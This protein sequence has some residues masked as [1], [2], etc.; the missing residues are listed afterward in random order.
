[1]KVSLDWIKDYV[2]LGED[3]DS[4]R[5]AYDLTMS[6]VEVEDVIDL[7]ASFENM[8]LGVLERVEAHPNADKLRVCAVNLGDRTE[9]IVCG[10]SNLREGMKVAAALPGAKVR[11]HGEGELTEIKRAKLRGVESF[12]M[13]CAASEIG[14]ADLFPA[15]SET[16]I[17]D[18]TE[19]DAPAGTPLADA[20][21]L[22]DVI[23]EIDNKSMT[24]R[25]DLWGHYGI[26]REIAALYDLPL[27]ELVPF[28]PLGLPPLK[29]EVLDSGRCP[30]YIG[31]LIEG[32]SV[33]A[34]P[35]IIRRRVWETG[36]RP[37][38][39]LVD[40]TNYV[41][42]A[43]GNP[44]HA[45]DADHIKGNIVVRRARQ[46]E[47]L[48]L[49]NGRE[50]SL[51][52][53][54]LVIADTESAVGLA[55]VMGGA[56]DSVLADTNRIILE[57]AN[58][59]GAGIRGTALRYDNRTDASTRYEKEIDPQ[60]CDVALALSMDLLRGLY[61]QMRITAFTDEY[62]APAEPTVIDV[63]LAWLAKRLGGG[64]DREVTAN[65][66]TRLGFTVE[67]REDTLHITVPSWRDTG[68]ISL[69]DDIME[70]IARM[71][72]YENFE[73][74]PITTAF[75]G[76]INQRD[77]DL[78][79]AVKEYLAFRCG[80]TEVFTYPWMRDEYVNAILGSTDGIL[81][82]STPPSPQESLIRSS[83]LPN[84]AWA[85]SQNLRYLNDFAIFETAKV[86]HDCD[87]TAPYDPAELLPKQEKVLGFAFAGAPKR[88]NELFRRVKGI[89]E[90]LPRYTHMTA[91]TFAKDEKPFYSDDVMW[92]D[93][94]AGGEAVG[95]F[96]LLRAEAA[97]RCGIKNSAVI[98]GELN[99][100]KLTPLPSRTN[101]FEHLP[102]YPS[103][104][105]DLSVIADRAVTWAQ[106]E[107][108]VSGS[109][110][111]TPLLRGVSF[112]EEYSGHQVPEGKKAVM[113]RL[114]I[115]SDERTLTSKEVEQ[116]ARAVLKTLTRELGVSLRD[117]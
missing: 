92:L 54:D 52:D 77:K 94:F 42:L 62:P 16:E 32:V 90:N 61:P 45:F 7:G 99:L 71:Y 114:T 73:P 20:L 17:M 53:E 83:T 110:E 82:L 75:K 59:S 15:E 69:K 115:G 49:L 97:V 79:R 30:R 43:T 8:V 26:A 67:Y 86:F 85:V 65:K 101:R 11:W 21:E 109:A 18:L 108:C 27:K 95:S 103:I 6:T 70:E 1:M 72:G 47:K 39:A 10:G 80:M 107:A 93:I 4:A 87:Y 9:T 28:D 68:D 3:F 29:V 81:R 35:Y 57:V 24:N 105:Y 113:L 63:P 2:P 14:L 98:L 89:L 76:F 41:M 112:M 58:F 88:V 46:D 84:L 64:G 48:L 33:K 13:I 102:V 56:K 55:G 38:N 96:G 100:E 51:C 116:T 91:L 36:M 12:G 74:S 60:R 37:I 106:I 5:L 111:K 23:L 50:L 104:S 34:A 44:T 40:I 25:P 66:L 78:E 19:F 31:A 117:F 22:R